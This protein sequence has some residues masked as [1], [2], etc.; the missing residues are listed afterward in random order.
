MTPPQLHIN[1]ELLSSAGISP[2]STVGAPGAQ[3][4][5]VTGTQGI[6]VK[7]PAAKEVAVATAGLFME[8]HIPKVGTLTKGWPS[9]MF[10]AGAPVNVRF[11]GSTRREAGAAPKLH[12]IVAPIQTCIAIKTP[13]S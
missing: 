4:A 13:L 8:E 9:I 6:G 5:G 11:T 1:C 7:T 10:A 3:G 12:I 2:M